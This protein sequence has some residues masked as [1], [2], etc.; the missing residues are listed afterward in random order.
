MKWVIGFLLVLVMVSAGFAGEIPYIAIVGN[1]CV[2]GSGDSV[3]IDQPCVANPFYFSP[4]HQQFLLDQEELGVPVCDPFSN[5]PPF[6]KFTRVGDATGCE[7]FKSNAP[8]DQPE[9][10]DV[11]GLGGE[12]NAVITT[13]SP[14]GSFFE[15]WIR[16]PRTPEGEINICI[17]CGV[18]KPNTEQFGVLACAAETGERIGTGFCTRQQKPAGVNPIV[19]AALPRLTVIAWPGEF[20]LG[21]KQFHLTAYKNPGTYNLTVG[22]GTVAA[23]KP[24]T[25]SAAL[26]VIDGTVNSRVLL[27][28]CMDK[29]V[30]AKIPVTGQINAAGE[31]ESDLTFGDLI[32]VRLEF[33]VHST[34][35]VYCHSQSAKIM[36]IGELD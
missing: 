15:W 28:S 24:M 22:T 5:V 7:M 11:Q 19:N 32:Q 18:L 3:V 8:I 35:D 33:P 31:T 2:V 20:S 34:V 10:C 6:D 17:Q 4:K 36:G 9:V 1:D 23:P 26:Q 30:I 14:S 13:L 16:L 21:F 29:C 27:K 25:N 12:P